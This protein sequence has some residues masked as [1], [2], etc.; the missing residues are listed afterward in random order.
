MHVDMSVP[1]TVLRSAREGFPQHGVLGVVRTLGRMGVRVVL[2]SPTPGGI[3]GSSTYVSSWQRWAP[4]GQAPLERLLATGGA[5]RPVLLPTDDRSAVFVDEHADVLREAFVLPS[6]PAGTIA[7]LLDKRALAAL[8]AR[9]GVPTPRT[10]EA[11]TVEE[12]DTFLADAPPPVVLKAD[13]DTLADGVG[14]SVVVA[15]TRDD[16]LAHLA[17]FGGRRLILQE[18][19]P[20]R[21]DAANWMFDGYLDATSTCLFGATGRKLHQYPAYSGMATFAETASNDTVVSL[22]LTLLRSVRYAGPVD[23]DFRFDAR[24]GRYKVV[25]VNPRV[26]GTFR[27]F[28]APNGIDVVRAA[29]LDLTGQA[30][31][32]SAVRDG[33][34]WLVETHAMASGFA[35][36]RD[37]W[38]TLGAWLRSLSGIEEGA[39]LGVDDLKPTAVAAG[40]AVIRA[41]GR[42]NRTR[43][44]ADGTEQ[45]KA[46]EER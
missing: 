37:G 33:R 6:M 46:E 3:A 2:A 7:P 31:P 19:I 27:L 16:V 17:G 22:A 45:T 34:K 39:L 28:T 25:D 32:V 30:V 5:E 18:H 23:I 13:V 24:D 12:V 29:Y 20:G 4:D 38:L 35:Y 11:S 1:V 9:L 40:H 21:P 42:L 14:R 8:A 10:A 36:R 44:P 43:R 41:A 15:Q 26:G